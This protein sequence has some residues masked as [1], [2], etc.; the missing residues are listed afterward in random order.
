MPR[1]ALKSLSNRYQIERVYLLTS[2][3]GKRIFQ[4]LARGTTQRQKRKDKKMTKKD[5]VMIAEIFKLNRKDFIEGEDG[6]SLIGIMAHQ[7]ANALQADNPRFN[8]ELFLNA[9]GINA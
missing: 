8:R 6:Y 9:C 3:A 7:I 4:L 2:G 5:Y 1:L